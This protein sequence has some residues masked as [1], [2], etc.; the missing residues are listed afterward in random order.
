MGN[1]VILDPDR[2]PAEVLRKLADEID[3]CDCFCA[4]IAV[5]VVWIRKDSRMAVR[6]EFSGEIAPVRG[7]VGSLA[8]KLDGLLLEGP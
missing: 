4:G 7:A 1:L 8:A 6:S 5:A 2:S 3:D